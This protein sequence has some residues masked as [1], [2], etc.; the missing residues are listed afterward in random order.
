MTSL[1]KGIV[2]KNKLRFQKDGFDLDLAYI[3]SAII[4]MGFPS[5]GREALYR[6]SYD[7]VLRFFKCYHDRHYKVYNLCSERGYSDQHFNGNFER[8]PFDDHN[9]PPIGVFLP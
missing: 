3:N 5:E 6:N 4:A 1:L 8:F 2:S 9:P 7:E